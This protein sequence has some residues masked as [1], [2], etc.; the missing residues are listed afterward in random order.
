MALRGQ[1]INN[2]LELWCLVA[3]GGLDF[4]ISSI[5]FQENDMGW[6]QQPLKERVSSVTNWNFDDSFHKKDL[7]LVIWVVGM[8][9]PL[10]KRNPS[11][12]MKYVSKYY[13]LTSV[14]K[15][16]GQTIVLYYYCGLSR[17]F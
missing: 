4:C 14:S 10:K 11:G 16:S 3:S 9:K 12:L 15:K 6:P 17:F 5:S 7:L 2:F 13:Q 8:I 1:R